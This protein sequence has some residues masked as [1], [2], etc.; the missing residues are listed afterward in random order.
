MSD[1][2]PREG[3]PYSLFCYDCGRWIPNTASHEM[4]KD[5]IY[6]H[7]HACH[8]KNNKQKDW[9]KKKE[10]RMT[11]QEFLSYLDRAIRIWRQKKEEAIAVCDKQIASCYIDAFQS[12]RVSVFGELLSMEDK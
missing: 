9:Q 6:S 3:G 7:S 1:V 5:G 10:M 11:E 12:V 4:K 2:R 8:K